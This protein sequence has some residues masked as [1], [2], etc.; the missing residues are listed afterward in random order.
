LQAVL[1]AIDALKLPVNAAPAATE[2]QI[3]RAHS[4]ALWQQLTAHRDAQSLISID[5]DTRMGPCSVSAA[6]HAAG[7]GVQAVHDVLDGKSARVFCAVRPP[8]HH[9]TRDQAMGFCLFNSIAVAAYAALDAGLQRVSIIDFDVHHGNG[10]Q[11]IFYA[12]PR[13][14]YLST[15]QSPLYPGTGT[16]NEIGAG[17]IVN[18]PLTPASSGEAFRA[19]WQQILRPA[20]ETHAPELILISA[21]FDAHRLDPLAGLNWNEDDYAWITREI[22]LLAN[23]YADGKI[24]SM[25]EGGYSAAALQSCA[26]AHLM[27]LSDIL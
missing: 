24:V 11:D 20:I 27:A 18:A 17:N 3:A 8:G 9:A 25:L 12:E 5:A 19:A 7:A 13:V 23:Q 2:V 1:D 21:G 10:T 16:R 26:R 6:L 22:V 4:R 14:Q 15:H